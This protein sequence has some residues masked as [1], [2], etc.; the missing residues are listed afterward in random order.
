MLIIFLSNLVFIKICYNFYYRK[1][2]LG[3][4]EI[5]RVSID[6]W[7]QSLLIMYPLHEKIE[8]FSI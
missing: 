8:I 4:Y 7:V 6:Y 2:L 3:S 5:I 1:Y